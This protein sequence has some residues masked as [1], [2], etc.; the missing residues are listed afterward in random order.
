MITNEVQYRA[1][2][3][4]LAKFEEAIANLQKEPI[5]A[6]RDH[7]RRALELG[8]LRSQAADL[9]AET[10]EY[11]LLRSGTQTTFEAASLAALA[12]ALVKA[13]IAKGWTQR[14][15]ADALGVAEQQIQRYET[16]EYAS[17]SLARLC[18]VADALGTEIRE[19][20]TLSTDAA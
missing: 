19:T 4:H 12:G 16:T 8:A 15:L 5:A 10:D 13:R 20:V 1:T 11:E 2:K 3:A 14:Q 6:P 7:K 9:E 17:A 18:D